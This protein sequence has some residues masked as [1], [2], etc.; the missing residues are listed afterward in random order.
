MRLVAGNARILNIDVLLCFRSPDA[1]SV[2]SF[3]QQLHRNLHINDVTASA[4]FKETDPKQLFMSRYTDCL[5]RWP[6][7]CDCFISAKLHGLET[8]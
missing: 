5:D 3:E 2:I 4:V 1:S 8:I 7:W 6:V